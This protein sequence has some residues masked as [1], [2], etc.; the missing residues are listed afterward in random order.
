[1]PN[2]KNMYVLG[3]ASSIAG[4]D[5]SA[6]EGPL[7][8]QKS[9]YLSS[10]KKAGL[11]LHWHT[12][13]KSEQN[14]NTTLKNITDYNHVLATAVADLTLNE[15]FFLVLGGDHTCAIGTWSGASYAIQKQGPLGLIWIDA[16]MDSHT[17]ET[18]PTGNYH[19]MPLA[20]LLG[21]GEPA[22]THLMTDLPKIQPRHLCLIGI[23]SFEKD[24]EQL[25][26]QLNVKVY[27]MDE[28]KKRGLNIIMQEAL[29]IVTNGTAGF[30]ISL[31]IDSIDPIDAPATD[32]CESG[33]IRAH[34]LSSV[35][36]SAAKNP[37]LLGIEI[38][39]FDPHRDIDQK[40]EK[41]IPELIMKMSG[42]NVI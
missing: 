4:P 2:R 21:R 30:G 16:H 41:L 38:T 19:G 26:N 15:Q 22:L 39:E 40:T 37:R 3:Y 17:P 10:L 11:H 18:S 35:L 12:M 34:V 23:R 24:E 27:Y 33:G 8:L 6:G 9:P 1:M 36:E 28:I 25:L 7:I 42:F 14:N 13:I 29:A 32:V 5:P 20:C 31:D